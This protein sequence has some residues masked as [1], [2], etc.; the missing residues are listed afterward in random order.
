MVDTVESLLNCDLSTDASRLN[1]FQKAIDNEMQRVE[2]LVEKQNEQIQEYEQ[3][4]SRLEELPRKLTKEIL[5]PFGSVG[6]MRGRI[7]KTNKVMVSLGDNYFIDQ[8]CYEAI[9]I[10]DRRICYMREIIERFQHE[11]EMLQSKVKFGN[12]LLKMEDDTYEIRE[13]YD[14]QK[15]H[16]L[17]WGP[18]PATKAEESLALP[19]KRIV[20]G[21]YRRKGI[22]GPKGEHFIYLWV[23]STSLNLH[24]TGVLSQTNFLSCFHS[25]LLK[26]STSLVEDSGVQSDLALKQQ[27]ENHE[28][29]LKKST[30][31]DE[32]KYSGMPKG[33]DPE[34][35]AKLMERLDMLELEES[36]SSDD[37]SSLD[38]DDL[39]E[40]GI[41]TRGSLNDE[42]STCSTIQRKESPKR[43][44]AAIGV[45]DEP[46]CS[47]GTTLE[48]VV[49]SLPVGEMDRVS[50]PL[51]TGSNISKQ[52]LLEK[53]KSRRPQH[54]VRFS[55][56]IECKSPMVASDGGDSSGQ[57][58]TE[59]QEG[60][61]GTTTADA[62]P[63]DEP[64]TITNDE[65]R[66]SCALP[67]RSILR[68]SAE[69]SPID[70]KAVAEADSRD[71]RLVVSSSQKAF[72][73][74]VCERI[75]PELPPSAAA[76]SSGPDATVAQG[77]DN[78][79]NPQPT[80]RVSRFKMYRAQL[81]RPNR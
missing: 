6:Y 64:K 37:E 36:W 72:T 42:L 44:A 34:E 9:Q 76:T 45:E 41:E 49:S 4:R 52:A 32:G 43:G 80:R 62:K 69:R 61:K 57:F 73:G 77:Q 81:D 35:Y 2:T 24:F 16:D 5:V 14:E 39:P 51:C 50:P 21:A 23:T 63:K 26:A 71:Q 66:F 40:G 11:K 18:W 54:S 13:P 58:E 3:L 1:Y 47:S 38:S 74:V 30:L 27:Q 79:P 78:Q 33:L 22:R 48:K 17:M 8:S 10:V 12:M 75:N 60:E 29:N 28:Q 67:R 56:E 65:P 53:K 55:N 70:T 19:S 68:N 7:E 15:E 31:S 25:D 46:C 59:A 20:C